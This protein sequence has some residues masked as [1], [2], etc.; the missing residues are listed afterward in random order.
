MDFMGEKH[1]QLRI[2]LQENGNK[3]QFRVEL[4]NSQEFIDALYRFLE[5]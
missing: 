3:L 4:Q 5:T 2:K 1:L